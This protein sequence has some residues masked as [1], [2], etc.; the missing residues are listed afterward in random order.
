MSYNSKK[1]IT[2]VVAG[3][4]LNIAYIIYALGEHSPAPDNL[5]SWAI[6]MLVFI[7]IGIAAVI[8]IQ[9]IFHIVT[10]IGI[11]IKEQEHDDKEI[12][13]HL[14]SLVVEDERDKLISLKSTHIGYV[15]VGIGF[16]VALAELALGMS[17]VVALHTLLG[18]FS[19]GSIAEGIASICFYEKGV[20]N[21]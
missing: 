7:G 12:E 2:S 18:A 9:I 19:V 16:V 8:V 15:F 10:A 14:L 11:A 1:T 17:S 5:K 20:R 13:R 21:G 3:V 4:L 6:A